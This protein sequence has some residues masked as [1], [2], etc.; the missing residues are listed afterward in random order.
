[1]IVP[2]KVLSEM[3]KTSNFF[4]L[5]TP[6]LFLFPFSRWPERVSGIPEISVDVLILSQHQRLICR[7]SPIQQCAWYVMPISRQILLSFLSPGQELFQT[8]RW[9][10]L[11]PWYMDF[12]YAFIYF[13]MLVKTWK[14]CMMMMKGKACSLTVRC[15]LAIVVLILSKAASP[16]N[17]ATKGDLDA[18]SAVAKYVD[19]IC[20]FLIKLAIVSKAASGDNFAL[21]RHQHRPK[22]VRCSLRPDATTA[23]C[24][25]AK[26]FASLNMGHL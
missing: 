17:S 11:V 18:R 8:F 22:T 1:M 25:T 15:K 23:E 24:Y 16:H 10:Y 3:R 4:F 14:E 19:K 20:V 5:S 13:A 21:H 9:Q 12:S 26:A 2:R 6:G 7:S